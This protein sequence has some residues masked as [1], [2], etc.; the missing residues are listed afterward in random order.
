MK[1]GDYT[2][3]I[4]SNSSFKKKNDRSTNLQNHPSYPISKLSSD[5]FND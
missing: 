5:P 3:S 1:K 2:R 4:N